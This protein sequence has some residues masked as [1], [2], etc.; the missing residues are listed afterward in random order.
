[1]IVFEYILV[2]KWNDKLL[3]IIERTKDVWYCRDWVVNEYV[4]VSPFEFK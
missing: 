4:C 2:W 1:M 3:T